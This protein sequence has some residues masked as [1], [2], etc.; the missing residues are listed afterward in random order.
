MKSLIFSAFKRVVQFSD[1]SIAAAAWLSMDSDNVASYVSYVAVTRRIGHSMSVAQVW[2]TAIVLVVGASFLT[3][4]I[5][6][7]LIMSTALRLSDVLIALVAPP[8]PQARHMMSHTV[9]QYVSPLALRDVS[10]A[11]WC[12]GALLILLIIIVSSLD[13]RLQMLNEQLAAEAQVESSLVTHY[14]GNNYDQALML[15]GH[16]SRVRRPKQS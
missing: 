16:S 2:L 9:G 1:L 13:H 5:L 10:S 8:H 15:A 4:P 3:L 11:A 12:T 7:E 6:V 14:C